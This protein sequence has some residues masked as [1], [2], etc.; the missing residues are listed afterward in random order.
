MAKNKEE[1]ADKHAKQF[2]KRIAQARE[3][4]SKLSEEEKQKIANDED[5]K[6][7]GERM[8]FES[9]GKLPSELDPNE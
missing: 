7:L 1:L 5:L 2:K 6:L 8:T 4:M 9:T 3:R